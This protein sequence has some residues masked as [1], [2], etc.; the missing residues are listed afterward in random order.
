MNNPQGENFQSTAIFYQTMPSPSASAL[1]EIQLEL[2]TKSAAS[3]REV[4]R[5]LLCNLL[6]SI[7][8]YDLEWFDGRITPFSH[9]PSESLHIQN[10]FP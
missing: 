7:F 9:R 6:F 5:L 10:I 8:F 3:K 2:F 1:D 4:C